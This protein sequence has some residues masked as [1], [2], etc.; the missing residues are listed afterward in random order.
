MAIIV[1]D[2]KTQP[3]IHLTQ[4]ELDQYTHDYEQAYRMYYGVVPTLEEYIRN[5]KSII[6]RV[7]AGGQNTSGP[8]ILKGK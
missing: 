8:D 7:F 1:T 5:R 6:E 2:K 3:D 4:A